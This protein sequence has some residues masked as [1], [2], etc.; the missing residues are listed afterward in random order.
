MGK[1]ATIDINVEALTVISVF[2]LLIG[3]FT[4]F[5]WVPAGTEKKQIKDE[6]TRHRQR[7]K[8]C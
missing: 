1:L 7:K 5:R 6:A 4:I 8:L 2:A 3:T